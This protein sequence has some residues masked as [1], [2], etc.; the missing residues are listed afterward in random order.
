MIT[1]LLYI[2]AILLSAACVCAKAELNIPPYP[3]QQWR[4]SVN[5]RFSTDVL[6]KFLDKKPSKDQLF[7]PDMLDLWL[8]DDGEIRG[9]STHP[10]LT[11][12][13]SEGFIVRDSSAIAYVP[14]A[15][16]R[17]IY[18]NVCA[19]LHSFHFVNSFSRTNFDDSGIDITVDV[20]VNGQGMSV[21]Y[22]KVQAKDGLPRE[23]A[24]LLAVLRRSLP[25][26]YSGLFD[27]LHVSKLPALSDEVANKY[28]QCQ[29][30][31]EW[32]TIGDVSIAYGFP[33]IDKAYSKAEKK[34]FPHANL[35]SAGGCV[36]SPDS[37]KTE[38]V[39]Y[40]SSCRKAEAEWQEKHSK[41]PKQSP[42]S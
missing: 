7:G 27:Y 17:T 14:Q 38:K 16:Q 5:F 20:E 10:V 23:V 11:H 6:V 29:L 19:V 3:P 42:R 34:L 13:L 2:F 8:T 24:S 1:R 37:P 40:C 30:H 9:S 4:L 21:K 35:Y 28:R 12:K 18:S 22:D 39:L 26:T 33:I 32:M 25:S 36:V 15:D 31:R 41:K